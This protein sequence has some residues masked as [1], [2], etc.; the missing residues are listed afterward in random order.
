MSQESPAE[1]PLFREKR[2]A[3]RRLQ[4]FVW[5]LVVLTL[6]AAAV[7][8]PFSLL[9]GL[10]A[11]VALALTALWVRLCSLTTEVRQDGLVVRLSPFRPHLYP[12]AELQDWHV[13]MTYPWGRSSLGMRRAPGVTVW[14]GGEGP[15]LTVNLSGGGTVWIGTDRPLELDEALQDM[16]SPGRRKRRSRRR[17]SA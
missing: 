8:E 9:V 3:S 5:G 17:R 11:A 4:Q 12:R 13:H 16:R 10:W 6:V 15:G 14:Q 2:E 1:A 7:L